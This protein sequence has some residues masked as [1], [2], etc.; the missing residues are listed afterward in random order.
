MLQLVAC[1]PVFILRVGHHDLLVA[2]LLFQLGSR[3]LLLAGDVSIQAR[4]TKGGEDLDTP[5]D[6]VVLA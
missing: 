1:Q 3:S 6:V 5:C 2:L 4:T